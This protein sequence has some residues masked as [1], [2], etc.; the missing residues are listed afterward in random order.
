MVF[1]TSCDTNEPPTNSTL[2][3]KL[4]DVSCTEAW[5]TL[6]TT[7]LQLPTTVTLKQ[8]DQIRDTIKLIKADSLLYIDSLLPNQNFQYQLSS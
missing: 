5:I 1:V 3:L 7:N 2:S 4:E 6:T 8:N